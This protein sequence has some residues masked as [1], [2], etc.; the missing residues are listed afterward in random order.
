MIINEITT[1]TVNTV[2]SGYVIEISRTGDKYNLNLTPLSKD[3]PLEKTQLYGLIEKI[4]LL[5]EVASK[6]GEK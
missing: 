4:K 3:T 1:R 5:V 2:A 6:K